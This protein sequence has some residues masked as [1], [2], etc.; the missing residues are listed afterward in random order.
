MAGRKPRG[1]AAKYAKKRRDQ[2]RREREAKKAI[3]H[4]NVVTAVE[5]SC[6]QIDPADSSAARPITVA[7]ATNPSVASDVTAAATV[8]SV[9]PAAQ[10][11]VGSSGAALDAMHPL[12]D[13]HASHLSPLKPTRIFETS[14]AK[15][16]PESK[17]LVEAFEK[18]IKRTPAAKQRLLFSGMISFYSQ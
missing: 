1:K 8:A 3:S 17:L 16:S 6:P 2:L 11:P 14:T 15:L 18:K 5:S 13:H 7:G 10:S 9:V 4:L 12:P